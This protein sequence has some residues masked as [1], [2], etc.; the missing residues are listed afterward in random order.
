MVH[1]G[2]PC[3]LAENLTSRSPVWVGVGSRPQWIVWF[4]L[5]GLCQS[6]LKWNGFLCA[7]HAVLFVARVWQSISITRA[8]F[9]L[10]VGQ[11]AIHTAA[12]RTYH[13]KCARAPRRHSHSMVHKSTR[14]NRWGLPSAR[15]ADS[16][17]GGLSPSPARCRHVVNR[18]WWPKRAR[19]R[20][21]ACMMEKKRVRKCWAVFFFCVCAEWNVDGCNRDCNPTMLTTSLCDHVIE[22]GGSGANFTTHVRFMVDP[23]LMNISGLPWISVIGSVSGEKER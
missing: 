7:A 2:V 19:A 5:V 11:S 4:P 23:L 14:P 13:S 1:C 6:S 3:Y 9:L 21:R 22:G 18:N 15:A 10:L 12:S 16:S 17:W 8:T 20:M